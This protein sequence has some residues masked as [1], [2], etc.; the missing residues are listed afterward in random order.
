MTNVIPP[1]S[2]VL[3]KPAEELPSEPDHLRARRHLQ[4]GWWSLLIFLSLGLLLEGF[5][6][7]KLG[8]Y[9]DHSNE[10][11]RLM[12]TLAHR[13]GTLLALVNVAFGLSLIRLTGWRGP[14]RG[15]ASACLMAG[16]TLLPAGF[17]VGGMFTHA[18]DPGLGI[19]LVPPG[20]LLLLV[21]VLLTARACRGKLGT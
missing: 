7:L 9:L 3:D 15:L 6:G 21:A 12:W 4:F 14:T 10:T 1:G 2:Q 17:L 18:G 5:H 19:V 8:W 13:H 20:G 16:T 11:R